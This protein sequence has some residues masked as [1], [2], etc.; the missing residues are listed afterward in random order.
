MKQSDMNYQVKAKTAIDR[1]MDYFG[2]LPGTI[3]SYFRSLYRTNMS[4]CR[5]QMKGMFDFMNT[6]QLDQV[7]LI[8][9][10]VFGQDHLE[11]L[12]YIGTTQGSP[13][14]PYLS[15]IC[16]QEIEDNLPPGVQV[17]MYADDMIFYGPNLSK[18]LRNLNLEEWLSDI[19]FTLH[20][21]KSG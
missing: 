19:G 9:K 21:E 10:P 14:S 1:S 3:K 12:K 16:I 8:T 2:L 18:W 4:L 7:S 5:R 15:A 20:P 6:Q 11:F 13:L 17:I